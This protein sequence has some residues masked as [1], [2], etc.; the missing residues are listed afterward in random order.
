MIDIHCHI[1]PGIDD[2]A[3]TFEDSA[4]MAKVAI[5]EG[6]T[7]IIATPHHNHHYQNHG[8]EIE[9]HVARLK[10]HLQNEKINLEILLGQEPRIT[11]DFLEQL[12]VG[13]IITLCDQGKYVHIELPSNQVPRYTKS[14]IF[15]LRLKGITP[16][17]VHP[18]RNSEIM[19]DP[20]LLY[21]LVTEGAL[22]QVTAASLTGEFGKNIQKFS[23]QLIQHNLTHFVASD[24]HNISN[25]SFNFK[26]AFKVIEKKIG[27]NEKAKLQ[28]NAKAMAKGDIIYSESPILIRKRK[29]LGIF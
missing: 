12:E 13:E 3:K 19:E 11:G 9:N 5:E 28:E 24:A 29:I 20:E 2:G 21:E 1:L 7:S 26:E 23:F 8:K 4:K 27:I 18:E 16:I 25:R 15:E 22:T 10:E 17:I 6:I 14:I